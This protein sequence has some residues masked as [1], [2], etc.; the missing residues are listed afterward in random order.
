MA[1]YSIRNMLHNLISNNCRL[2]ILASAQTCL[3]CPDRVTGE[4]KA[5]ASQYKL[6]KG[7]DGICNYDEHIIV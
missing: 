3:T 4:A 6:R 5:S 7:H 2:L 1:L